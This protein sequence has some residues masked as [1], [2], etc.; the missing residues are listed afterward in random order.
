M[1]KQI[2]TC[3]NAWIK[4]AAKDTISQNFLKINQIKRIFWKNKTFEFIAQVSQ[5]SEEIFK[6]YHC[7]HYDVEQSACQQVVTTPY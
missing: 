3:T 2:L 6:H 7:A 4:S 1:F 5:K